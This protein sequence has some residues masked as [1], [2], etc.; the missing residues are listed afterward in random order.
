L[1]QLVCERSRELPEHRDARQLSEL[2]ALLL[3]LLLHL[4][5]VRDVPRDPAYAHGPARR[6]ELDVTDR[7][8]PS[9]LAAER[10]AILTLV[11]GTG[12]KRGALG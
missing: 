3:D 7:R 11:E 4:L 10:D 5:A 8:D 9:Q 12:T 1:I 2:V 6:V